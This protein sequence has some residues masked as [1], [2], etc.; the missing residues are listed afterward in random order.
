MDEV[1]TVN[2]LFNFNQLNTSLLQS[3]LHIN[4][5]CNREKLLLN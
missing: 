2:N 3:Y 1:P 5:V 4:S